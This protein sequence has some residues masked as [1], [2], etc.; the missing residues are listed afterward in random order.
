MYILFI[1]PTIKRH[2]ELLILFI[3]LSNIDYFD[4]TSV[5]LSDYQDFDPFNID[6]T[7]A[8]DEFFAQI[9]FIRKFIKSTLNQKM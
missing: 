3:N 9:E 6:R 4:N 8:I 7:G 1:A 5:S 2:T